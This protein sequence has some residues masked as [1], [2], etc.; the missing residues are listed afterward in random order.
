[1]VVFWGSWFY[2]AGFGVLV[3]LGWVLFGS[4]QFLGKHWYV[5]RIKRVRCLDQITGRRNNRRY[6][7]QLSVLIRRFFGVHWSG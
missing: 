6:N 1:M 5:E 3:N 2:K 4:L 7:F